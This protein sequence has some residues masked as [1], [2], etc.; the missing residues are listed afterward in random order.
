MVFEITEVTYLENDKGIVVKTNGM[1]NNNKLY[2]NATINIGNMF[3]WKNNVLSANGIPYR[4]G[5]NYLEQ[6]ER[7]KG[8]LSEWEAE[9]LA[10]ETTNN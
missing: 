7:S 6:K 2:W 8:F 5:F 3:S 10:K 9:E 1:C 4:N